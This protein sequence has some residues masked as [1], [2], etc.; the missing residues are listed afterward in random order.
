ML[1]I[2]LNAEHCVVFLEVASIH[3]GVNLGF[4]SHSIACT[5]HL[6][7]LL[8]RETHKR[9]DSAYIKKGKEWGH[10]SLNET[11]LLLIGFQLLPLLCQLSILIF[12]PILQNDNLL[13]DVVLFIFAQVLSLFCLLFEDF[14]LLLSDKSQKGHTKGSQP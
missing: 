6:R 1:L 2:F 8:V 11:S 7:Y 3:R 12:E 5:V 4:G 13:A 9:Q 10:K 14:D